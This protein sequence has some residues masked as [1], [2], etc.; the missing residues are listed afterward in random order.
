M[1]ICCHKFG[2]LCTLNENAKER[3]LHYE[4]VEQ[5]NCEHIFMWNMR[6]RTIV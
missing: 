6:R 1:K 5:S 4:K 2:S 3:N